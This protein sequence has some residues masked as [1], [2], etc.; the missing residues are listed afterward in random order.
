MSLFDIRGGSGSLKGA[1]SGLACQGM[2]DRDDSLVVQSDFN[3]AQDALDVIHHFVIPKADNMV[4]SGFEESGSFGIV[5]L[6]VKVLTTIQLDD[7]F[8][9]RSTEIRDILA[10]RVLSPKMD[11]FHAVGT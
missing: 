5:F 4:A 2:F 11:I 9:A 6:L 8:L 7:E 1:F 10:N 3:S